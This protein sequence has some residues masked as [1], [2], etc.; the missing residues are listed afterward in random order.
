LP[1]R[2]RDRGFPFD[3]KISLLT[4]SRSIA[5]I[6]NFDIAPALKKL[7]NS[8]SLIANCEDFKRAV[9][10]MVD[11]IRQNFE[12]NAAV[13]EGGCNKIPLRSQN[14]NNMRHVDNNLKLI[15]LADALAQFIE[16]K[17]KEQI[18]PLTVQQLKQRAE[19]FINS[20]QLDTVAEITSAH[21]LIYR[22]LLLT[23][24]RSYKSNK[25][26]LAA[27]SQF[28]RWCTLMQY[29]AVNPFNEIKL[30]NHA[31]A[32]PDSAR[33]R[34]QPNELKQLFKSCAFKERSSELKWVTLLMLYHGLRPSEA[35]QLLVKDITEHESVLCLRV[36]NEGT[37][38][39]V[40]NA[41]SVR[42]VPLHPKMIELGFNHYVWALKDKHQIQ[43][44]SYRPDNEN[45]DWSRQY[46]Q[47][48]GR[49]QTKIGMK[50]GKRP[51]AY[52][53]RH[54]FIDEMKQ[55]EI[56]ENIVA[57][58][59]GHAN[60]KVTFGRYGKKYKI[61]LLKKHIDRIDYVADFIEKP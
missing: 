58:L 13:K 60:N 3:L 42:L 30:S 39:R 34:W 25:E 53:F 41:S 49:L 51:T 46:C 54:T 47:A 57:E 55:L 18:R 36:S 24:G 43:L 29:T 1:K 22:D 8:V 27:V 20:T 12:T 9:D 21:G 10:Q 19:H 31:V 17:S 26:Y 15:T 14:A 40:K 45:A 44:F 50:A 52:S 23:E 11:V 32:G 5:V 2:L 28:F 61:L 59:V 48:F 33:Q 35:C 56:D 4:K 16:S 37:E 38:Q 6:R 7:I